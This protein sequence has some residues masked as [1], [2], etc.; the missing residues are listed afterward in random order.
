[1]GKEQGGK[2]FL[3]K[4]VAACHFLQGGVGSRGDERKRTLFSSFSVQGE[5]GARSLYGMEGVGSQA[6]DREG[7]EVHS[8][9][10]GIGQP[11]LSGGKV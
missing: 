11:H 9:N 3:S 7:E 4:G 2:V 1:M 5:E 10:W 8:K 6:N